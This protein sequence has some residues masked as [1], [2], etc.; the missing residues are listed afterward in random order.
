MEMKDIAT[1]GRTKEIVEK[2]NFSTKKSLGQNFLIDRNIIQEVLKKARIN[3]DIGVIEVGPGIGSLTEQL[4]KVAKKVV[5]FEIDD[6]LIPVLNDTLSPYDN[7]KIIHEDVLQ[8]DI[9]KVIKEEFSDVKEVIV[10]ANLPYYIT[11]PIL[12][13]FLMYHKEISRFY[14]MMQK[15]VGERLSASPSSKSYGSLSIAI[16]Y[17][18]EAKI[19]QNV[20]KT[21]FMPPPNVDSIVVELVRHENPPVKVDDEETFFKLTRGAFVMRRKTI[22]NNYQSLFKDGKKKKEDILAMLEAAEIDPKRRGE[23]LSIQEYA[24]IYESFKNSN[25]KF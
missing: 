18:T 15:E 22:Y 16:Q 21:V 17:Y 20:P 10:V 11:T 24:R 2:Y 19:I 1:I 9:G 25:L 5:A 8:A 13:N 6:R 23:S 14:T 4:A 7:I 12:M 3:D